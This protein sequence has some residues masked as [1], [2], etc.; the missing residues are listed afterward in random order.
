MF[1]FPNRVFLYLLFFTGLCF[2]E[3]CVI[4]IFLRELVNAKK[5]QRACV[6][7]FLIQTRDYGSIVSELYQQCDCYLYPGGG[8]RVG[9]QGKSR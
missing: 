3:A 4:T 6:E 9:T 8:G 7:P 2:S 1:C 5:V